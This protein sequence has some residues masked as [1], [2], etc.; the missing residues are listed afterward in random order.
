MTP[1]GP[2]SP[3]RRK[4]RPASRW[5][6]L[7]SRQSIR[8]SRLSSQRSESGWGASSLSPLA[9]QALD[10]GAHCIDHHAS[11]R[12]CLTGGFNARSRAEGPRMCCSAA[13]AYVIRCARA[14]VSGAISLLE[15][16]P[17][18]TA[19]P[20]SGDRSSA[21]RLFAARGGVFALWV[22]AIPGAAA[23]SPAAGG[24]RWTRCSTV[25]LAIWPSIT[26]LAT[27]HMR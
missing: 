25:R 6:G 18:A 22:E 13:R 4:R 15:G 11:A 10:V 27:A 1:C 7:L 14:V 2:E 5:V 16:L 26:G 23:I 24:T 17:I 3:P 19:I 20:L 8:V 12:R 9:G 21:V